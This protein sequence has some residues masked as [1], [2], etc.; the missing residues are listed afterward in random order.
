MTADRVY[1]LARPKGHKPPME[2]WKLECPESQ[3][4]IYTAYIGVQRHDSEP[5]TIKSFEKSIETIQAWLDTIDL[6]ERS[7]V[8]RFEFLE[9]DD[10]PESVLWMCYWPD[11]V[12]YENCIQHLRLTD[13]YNRIK[14]PKAV[15]LWLERHDADITP[16]NELLRPRLSPRVGKAP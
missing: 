9:G 14:R 16:R 15:G 13:M 8:E 4:E 7:A 3:T 10:E 12:A 5:S 1:P 11:S 2:R 6:Q